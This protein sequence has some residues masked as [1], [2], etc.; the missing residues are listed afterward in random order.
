MKPVTAGAEAKL[1][2]ELLSKGSLKQDRWEPGT[3]R[4]KRRKEL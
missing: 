2:R 4:K 3:P 1:G